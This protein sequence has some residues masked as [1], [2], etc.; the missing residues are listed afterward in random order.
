MNKTI[1]SEKNAILTIIKRLPF[2]KTAVALSFVVLQTGCSLLLPF[3]TADIV[4]NGIIPGDISYILDGG[5]VMILLSVAGLC[6]A[7]LSIYTTSKIAYNLG[8]GLRHDIYKKVLSFSNKEFDSIGTASLITRNTNDVSQVQGVIDMGLKFMIICPFYLVGGIILTWLLNPL[9]GMIFLSAVP[10]LAVSTYIVFK[11]ATPLY[12]RIQKQVDLLN[13]YFR[14]GLIGVKVIRA[15]TREEFEYEKYQ[16]ENL[17]FT[18]VSIRAGTIMSLFLP[19]VTMLMSMT[20]IL[21]TWTGGEL[22]NFGETEIGSVMGAVSYASLILFG[23]TLLTTIILMIPRGQTSAKRIME[24]LEMPNSITDPETKSL[25]PKEFTLVF[26]HVSFGY[27]GANKPAVSE[28]SFQ[29]QKGETVAIVGGTGAGKTTLVNLIERFYDVK[30]GSIK[31]GGIDIREMSQSELRDIISISPQKSTLFQGTIRE[32]LQF[33]SP[34]ASDDDIWHALFM[35][36]ADGFVNDLSGKL[37]AMVDKN[38]GNF[39]GGQKQ[40]LCIARALLKPA[41]IYIF[42]DSF[43]ALDFKTDAM[44]RTRMQDRLKDAITIIIAQRTSTVMDADLILVLENGKPAG[45]GTHAKLLNS[46]RVYQEILY[47][48]VYKE[49]ALEDL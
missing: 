3:I 9:F 38:G 34:N 21:I 20:I 43:S 35:A 31:I 14:E 36:D 4:N 40:R 48:Q 17:E 32:N 41:K 6:F 8:R 45:V 11:F 47:S 2:W 49:D 1:R 5:K 22:V 39:S 27:D 19:L 10:F 28:I 24:V 18:K 25:S 26:D 30:T 37:S 33:G 29:I 12:E 46:N 15:F 13:R 44:I 16:Q 23:F 42:D 7:F